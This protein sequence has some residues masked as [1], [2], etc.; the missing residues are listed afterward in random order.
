MENNKLQKNLG[1]AAALSTVVG[2]VIGGG[3]FFK[4][5]AI[6]TATGGAP[7]IGILSWIIGGLI[8]L[9]A[10]L[11]VAEIAVVIP[12]TGG[13]MVYLE[14]V[15]GEKVGY[16]TGWMQCVLFY[17]SNACEPAY[18]P[19]FMHSSSEISRNRSQRIPM[20]RIWWGIRSARTNILLVLP[21]TNAKSVNSR[22]TSL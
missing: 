19:S 20:M 11:T 2:M 14:E 9:C 3:V 15:F 6:Y 10:G 7:G 8:T 4:P 17:Y 12:K 13:M 22:T 1:F 21:G 5:Q 18:T 16:L